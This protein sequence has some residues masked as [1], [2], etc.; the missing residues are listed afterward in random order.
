[1]RATA[2]VKIMRESSKIDLTRL[3]AA[4]RGPHFPVDP[5]STKAAKAKNRR[6]E[7]ILTPDLDELFKLLESN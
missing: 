5:G 6:I 2:V 7:I 1:M 4:G 3:T